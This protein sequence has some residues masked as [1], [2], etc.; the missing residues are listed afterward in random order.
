MS[1]DELT[2]AEVNALSVEG[3]DIL[4]RGGSIDDLPASDLATLEKMNTP[5][6]EEEPG[7]FQRNI[8]QP[9]AGKAGDIWGSLTSLSSD[10]I[11]KEALEQM[12][13]EGRIT[14][15]EAMAGTVEPGLG[16]KAVAASEAFLQNAFD[17]LRVT[18][19]QNKESIKQKA[20]PEILAD[21]MAMDQM[22]ASVATMNAVALAKGQAY[23]M[24]DSA[25]GILEKA[26]NVLSAGE[27]AVARGTLAALE[28][29]GAMPREDAIT[30]LSQTQVHGSDLVD[31][32]WLPKTAM[33]KI[34]R[35]IVA[36]AADVA[37][38]PLS[39][40]TFGAGPAIRR[41][42]AE[43]SAK[44]GNRIVTD[45]RVLSRIERQALLAKSD[46]L[47]VVRK[48]GRISKLEATDDAL[49]TLDKAIAD[50]GLAG[51]DGEI[52]RKFTEA[53]PGLGQAVQDIIQ[54]RQAEKGLVRSLA[55]G[56]LSLNFAF[57][58][59]FTRVGIETDMP[60]FGRGTRWGAQA[61][62]GVKDWTIDSA[63][64]VSADIIEKSPLA[65]DFM[66]LG[67]DGADK[68]SSGVM[69][70]FKAFKTFTTR[71][72]WDSSSNKFINK[73]YGNSMWAR[74]EMS[75]AIAEVG[76]DPEVSEL[77]VRWLNQSPTFSDED[78]LRRFAPQGPE[79]TMR[80]KKGK[81]LDDVPDPGLPDIEPQYRSDVAVD[82]RR[83][84]LTGDIESGLS[85]IPDQL[86]VKRS[87]LQT[88]DEVPGKRK[89]DFEY[90]VFRP[91]KETLQKDR[92]RKDLARARELADQTM[93]Q[94]ELKSPK[95]AARVRKI[96][97]QFADRI[98][99]MEKRKIP[100]R[101]LNPFD[102]TIPVEERAMGYFPHILNPDYI[103]SAGKAKY[104]EALDAFS[105][106]MVELGLA[107]ATQ[108]GRRDRRST[109]TII[110][111]VREA[112]GIK[113]PVFVNDPISASY[114]RMEDMD[115]LIAQYDMFKEI[116]PLA[117]VKPKG[118]VL[119][120]VVEAVDSPEA[121]RLAAQMSDDVPRGWV[122]FDPKHFSTPVMKKYGGPATVQS[123]LL[124][125]KMDEKAFIE[126]ASFLPQE[127][128]M[129][130]RRGA[131]IYFPEDVAN[132]VSYLLQREKGGLA[133]TALDAFNY[134]FRNGALFGTGYQGMNALSNLT[135]Y[136]TARADLHQVGKAS[137]FLYD[138]KHNSAKIRG[139]TF[140][141]GKGSNQITMTGEELYNLA[142]DTGVLSNSMVSEADVVSDI[143][144][145]VATTRPSR[146]KIGRQVKSKWDLITGFKW[147][148]A[149]A[150]N[151]D[152]MFR[153]GLF[154]DSLD[155]GYSVSGAKERLDMFFYD[156][157]DV[158]KGQRFASQV[159]P[160]SSFGLK[161]LE[162][163][164]NRAKKLDFT[165]VTIPY[166]AAEV[167]DG[168]FVDDYQTRQY[169]KANL[170]VYADHQILGE[171]LPGGQQLMMELPFVVNSLKM[172]MNP[173]ESIHPLVSMIGLA[174]TALSQGDSANDPEFDAAQM[175]SD[176]Y[177]SA[178]NQLLAE[179]IQ[180][181]VPPTIKFP[182]T[183]AQMQN[184]DE[185]R[186]LPFDF[187]KKY[188]TRTISEPGNPYQKRSVLN[189]Q[190]FGEAMA[191][192]S[193]DWFYNVMMYGQVKAPFITEGAD[194]DKQAMY[195]RYVKS[196]FRNLTFGAARM[197]DMD[198][199]VIT[200]M[201]AIQR[202]M[203]KTR[204]AIQEVNREANILRD[205]LATP[206][207]KMKLADRA[208]EK[209]GQYVAEMIELQ[210]RQAALKQFYGFYL[211][212]Q[213]H[214][215]LFFDMLKNAIQ[216]E[217]ELTAEEA[218]A[219]NSLIEGT[220]DMVPGRV[221]N[222]E[223]DMMRQEQ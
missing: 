187:I 141:F 28:G 33:G 212:E 13:A 206:K 186:S 174:G 34:G 199:A 62:T 64:R 156:F 36:F 68:L 191:K 69:N 15:E 123:E 57:R 184:P 129:A 23:T 42:V 166:Y 165:P 12:I 144:D 76:A 179:S 153:M 140:T 203:M 158:S 192:Q 169:L 127:Y 188:K 79:F 45:P 20:N 70:T 1:P 56:D 11:R 210:R 88:V 80:T 182:I 145:M 125:S 124:A 183:M 207:L 81:I 216:P 152:N 73:Q 198:R 24:T 84:L 148:R 26:G 40:M 31:Y 87:Q 96:R 137:K 178:K 10:N 209:T 205:P 128:K 8:A 163:V 147:N 3:L 47:N 217:Q 98:A 82:G 97:E 14:R 115:N 74:R 126:F 189:A 27:Q 72:L 155:K 175:D 204:Q 85:V 195:G 92:M 65:G 120:K 149:F 109:Q 111:S 101:V 49:A 168:A 41:M 218:E 215:G 59:P 121:A 44:V 223:L 63:A 103:D 136:M 160:F 151:N 193:P 159:I 172:F 18:E 150:E 117:R 78:M 110:D 162:S 173:V 6:S 77:M 220:M 213:K 60:L 135:T 138:A 113:D 93:A 89:L 190:E 4:E 114:S 108:A 131:S 211:S 201:A 214:G 154:M 30:L 164:V 170:P 185:V 2:D 5:E 196:Q 133:R 16:D 157:R 67:M 142:A 222:I 208:D 177:Q 90:T 19:G 86:P 35:G 99:E 116:F 197:Q 102:E 171:A 161:S 181:M 32:Y 25:A 39:Y 52:V 221:K 51:L 29:I 21:M 180:M 107:D 139:K 9:I 202:Q 200:R 75:E 91:T 53:D 22:D 104:K 7:W 132:R 46:I 71:P 134:L 146:E 38:D 83:G 17:S 37:M 58:L 119:E 48:D 55:D 143:W 130:V 118:P 122:E 54:A 167:L 219:Q 43:G 194:A 94:L 61:A 66:R 100:F 50:K 95:A 106:H 105:D 176:L 112:S